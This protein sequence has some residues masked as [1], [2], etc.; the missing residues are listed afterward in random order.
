[1][2]SS[3]NWTCKCLNAAWSYTDS[4]HWF[5]I[6]R[7]A[8][9]LLADYADRN[10]V[11]KLA[12]KSTLLWAEQPVSPWED[13][14]HSIVGWLCTSSFAR[15][16]CLH[17]CTWQFNSRQCFMQFT[18]FAGGYDARVWG[19]NE[20][21][22]K[23]VWDRSFQSHRIQQRLRQQSPMRRRRRQLWCMPAFTVTCT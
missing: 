23:A 10:A 15:T 3:V 19:N 16:L 14:R 12:L 13:T 1:M 20:G 6:E 17:S 11:V 7:I 18:Q 9:L 5:L 21:R 8:I 22:S 2:R 4:H